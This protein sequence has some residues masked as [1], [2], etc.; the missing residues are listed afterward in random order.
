MIE[1]SHIDVGSVTEGEKYIALFFDSLDWNI[2]FETQVRLNDLEGDNKK[3]R[4]ADFYLPKYEVYVE[5]LGQ[6]DVSED[7]RN[8]YREKREV[9]KKNNL[10]F[11]EIYPNQLGILDFAFSYRVR[12][13]LSNHGMKKELFKFNFDR[14]KHHINNNFFYISLFFFFVSWSDEFEITSL[15]I[16]IVFLLLWLKEL[17]GVYTF[18]FKA[19]E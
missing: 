16:C 1:D 18:T 4:I 14:L 8:R 7:H 6:W 5:F 11:I 15:L 10:P 9:Y 3:Y 12:K 13:T 19:M 2:E 17:K